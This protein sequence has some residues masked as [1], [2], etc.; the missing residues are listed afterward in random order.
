MNSEQKI[1]T[2]LSMEEI[3]SNPKILGDLKKEFG[4]SKVEELVRIYNKG[5]RMRNNDQEPEIE[6][7][8][9]G[10]LRRRRL[11]EDLRLDE[12]VNDAVPPEE[13]EEMR[14]LTDQIMSPVKKIKTISVAFNT[15]AD[16][17][18]AGEVEDEF[19][20]L[21]AIPKRT[22]KD[23]FRELLENEDEDGSEENHSIAESEDTVVQNLIQRFK[24]DFNPSIFT[25]NSNK[26][27]QEQRGINDILQNSG[28]IGEEKNGRENQKKPLSQVRSNQSIKQNEN[29]G[30]EDS[31]ESMRFKALLQ[32]NENQSMLNSLKEIQIPEESGKKQLSSN[33]KEKKNQ[34][35]L[36]SLVQQA[37]NY[38]SSEGESKKETKQNDL[39]ASA[40]H[41]FNKERG[42]S[43][44]EAKHQRAPSC[45]SFGINQDAP[46]NCGS[47]ASLDS[48]D[49]MAFGVQDILGQEKIESP[50]T[51][52]LMKI[53]DQE[54]NG[55]D[56]DAKPK[57]SKEPM[58][59]ND[60]LDQP[61]SLISP[62]NL[63]Q[64]K[65][66]R[67]E[68]EA[69]VGD[70]QVMERNSGKVDEGEEKDNQQDP[71]RKAE[72]EKDFDQMNKEI[73]SRKQI[74]KDRE[75]SSLDLNIP[76]SEKNIEDS[77]ISA[78]SLRHEPPGSH[79]SAPQINILRTLP[80]SQD[81]S[82]IRSEPC[83][84]TRNFFKTQQK[85]FTRP[86]RVNYNGNEIPIPNR[87]LRIV[88][89]L[90]FSP[91]NEIMIEKLLE[92][93]SGSQN[94]E[95]CE[96]A[97]LDPKTAMITSIAN[98]TI[99]LSRHEGY[100][101][102]PFHQ[103]PSRAPCTWMAPKAMLGGSYY[104]RRGKK[105]CEVYKH[106]QKETDFLTDLD[107]SSY[108]KTPALYSNEN[109]ILVLALKG[110]VSYVFGTVE[111]VQ[112]LNLEENV[113]LLADITFCKTSDFDGFARLSMNG[114]VELTSFGI[115]SKEVSSTEVFKIKLK[116]QERPF[117]ISYGAGSRDS[118][119]L[120]QLE[121][122][123]CRLARL[124]LL[125]LKY[126]FENA[127][128][129][130]L[131]KK[132]DKSSGIHSFYSLELL[133]YVFQEHLKGLKK[134]EFLEFLGDDLGNPNIYFLGFSRGESGIGTFSLIWF[135]QKR[136]RGK[137]VVTVTRNLEGWM[138]PIKK[139]LSCVR[140]SKTS[141]SDAKV[142]FGV[143]CMEDG[144][145]TLN[146]V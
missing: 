61:E 42:F 125:K 117:S 90:P 140:L 34:G 124:V 43:D 141:G 137:F 72:I 50:N 128:E 31:P 74:Q 87:S 24:D 22:R 44:E 28:K 123:K 127:E 46:E 139:P 95:K 132:E 37:L 100:E 110:K 134:F 20:E 88:N 15:E 5:P 143:L 99:M 138:D 36:K 89:Y 101:S 4:E 96:L 18:S 92:F 80:T 130:E 19:D 63:S 79:H 94:P 30:Q 136:N 68:A 103:D 70:K 118:Y 86:E 7:G 107:F 41:N 13:L 57:Q 85:L 69:S 82:F 58:M 54:N 10:P 102:N 67:P 75:I 71:L 12:A 35:G 133:S 17:E 109:D 51:T 135:G 83:A 115:E 25:T 48:G 3:I 27:N 11:N 66:K 78:P 52:S 53:Q 33:Q 145:V 144:L 2:G 121:T 26:N 73:G 62:L 23:L 93:L 60:S 77:F 126:A 108:S 129:M 21:F 113:G 47:I 106:T 56:F 59:E 120:V 9:Q 38:K 116:D 39:E 45:I 49:E 65:K 81:Q 112:V 97:V 104:I 98:G 119:F 64:N 6:V 76:R 32:I 91:K 131:Q 142:G 14:E 1:E 105:I 84:P 122:H 55:E 40:P 111:D 114:K 29:L 16:R 146:F 8:A